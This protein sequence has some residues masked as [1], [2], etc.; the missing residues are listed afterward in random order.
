MRSKAI[1]VR[2]AALSANRQWNTGGRS[3]QIKVTQGPRI[4]AR[5]GTACVAGLD[6]CA[7]VSL[8]DTRHYLRE[9]QQALDAKGCHLWIPDKP[10]QVHGFSGT[11][12]PPIYGVLFDAPVEIAGHIHTESFFV[13]D[14]ATDV[15]LG[16][17][18]LR[19]YGAIM[20]FT[21][22]ECAFSSNQEGALDHPTV[23][24]FS[25]QEDTRCVF[26]CHR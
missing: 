17:P 26:A 12:S 9:H 4:K 25:L 5:I 20:D 21:V 13:L 22:D 3:L 6:S 14:C 15:L 24:E 23:A 1:A 11:T 8:M 16:T 19:Q 18:F 7:D 2:E 10:I